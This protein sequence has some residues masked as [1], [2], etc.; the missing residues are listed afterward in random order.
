MKFTFTSQSDNSPLFKNTLEFECEYIGDVVENFELFLRGTGFH[1]G[2]I[3]ELLYHKEP[4][5]PYDFLAE[6]A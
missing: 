2:N 4:Q 1:Q 5:D 3:E 6:G